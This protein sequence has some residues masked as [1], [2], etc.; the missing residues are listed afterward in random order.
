MLQ[1][2]VA[3]GIDRILSRLGENVSG[4]Y[5]FASNV[6]L[7]FRPG[8]LMRNSV[9]NVARN[10]EDNK[11]GDI[12]NGKC[13]VNVV[14]D[15]SAENIE[16][17]SAVADNVLV[18]FA[19]VFNLTVEHDGLYYANGILVSNCDSLAGHIPLHQRGDQ[20]AIPQTLPYL[21]AAWLEREQQQETYRVMARRP[22]WTR[23]P[24]PELSFS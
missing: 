24:V 21:S 9:R 16:D 18:R 3:N 6:G 20:R 10:G 11:R 23:H 5:A 12:G 7:P 19:E 13:V 15:F 1:Q 17:S 2:L 8:L 22:R 4:S 14:D